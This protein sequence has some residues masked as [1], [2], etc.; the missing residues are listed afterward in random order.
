[1]LGSSTAKKIKILSPSISCQPNLHLFLSSHSEIY[2]KYF[3]MPFNDTKPK[4]GP[5]EE[6]GEGFGLQRK[7]QQN[8]CGP[9]CVQV[10]SSQ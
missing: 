10:W 7:L 9:Y 1:M 4:A 8:S 2:D 6:T 5:P 3:Q